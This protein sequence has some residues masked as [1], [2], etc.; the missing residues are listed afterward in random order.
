MHHFLLT[1]FFVLLK[2]SLNLSK[3]EKQR[4]KDLSRGKLFLYQLNVVVDNYNRKRVWWTRRQRLTIQES[5]NL[6]KDKILLLLNKLSSSEYLILCWEKSFYIRKISAT[7]Q[8][9]RIW[10]TKVLIWL[11][12]YLNIFIRKEDDTA[13]WLFIIFHKREAASLYLSVCFTLI[14]IS[15]EISYQQSNVC[16]CLSLWDSI[17]LLKR[18]EMTR[19]CG[20]NGIS[21]KISG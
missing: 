4:K 16:V 13:F 1:I 2:L 5:A 11:V 7:Y 20:G 9:A 8:V 3:R 15:T 14:F 12:I 19:I 18:F 21:I 17:E 10:K 6:N